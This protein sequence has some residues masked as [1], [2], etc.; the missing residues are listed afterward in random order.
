MI[1]TYRRGVHHSCGGFVVMAAQSPVTPLLPVRSNRNLRICLQMNGTDDGEYVFLSG[2]RNY[3][4]FS[5]IV[6]WKGKE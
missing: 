1:C 3:L 6:E 4:N 2:E 5:R